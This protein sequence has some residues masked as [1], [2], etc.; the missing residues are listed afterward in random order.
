MRPKPFP[1]VLFA[2]AAISRNFEVCR[3]GF[4]EN[5]TAA[6]FVHDVFKLVAFKFR[7]KDAEHR[8]ATFGSNKKRLYGRNKA[9]WG[10][11]SRVLNSSLKTISMYNVS[12][13]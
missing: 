7:G 9:N 6:Q 8:T 13:A 5:R 2:K 4:A 11:T 3:M 12:A 1:V 10:E